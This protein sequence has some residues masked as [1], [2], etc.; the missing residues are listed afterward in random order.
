M[1]A[2]QEVGVDEHSFERELNPRVKTPAVAPA[3]VEEFEQ[4]LN[5][6]VRHGAAIGQPGDPRQDLR[7]ACLLLR[8]ELGLTDE[9]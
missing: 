4:R 3:A 8:R 2:Q 1:N 5:V 6:G 7:G 9:D